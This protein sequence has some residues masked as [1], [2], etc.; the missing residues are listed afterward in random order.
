MTNDDTTASG[1][2]NESVVILNKDNEK[3]EMPVP[4]FLE[5]LKDIPPG[6]GQR[7]GSN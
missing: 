5:V 6:G 7:H 1:R 4:E 3:I 2:S